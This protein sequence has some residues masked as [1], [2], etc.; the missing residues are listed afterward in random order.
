M[1]AHNRG[2][3]DSGEGDDD[4]DDESHRRVCVCVHDA[5]REA[6]SMLRVRKRAHQ[7]RASSPS[8]S[9]LRI[10]NKIARAGRIV[11]SCPR[12]AFR[13]GFASGPKYANTC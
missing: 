12:A 10:S 9:L 2:N 4:D 11:V 8:S 1:R 7:S 6:T 3:D 13:N 5:L